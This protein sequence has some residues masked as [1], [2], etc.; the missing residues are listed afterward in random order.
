[1]SRPAITVP[2]TA[3][4]IPTAVP[5]SA[6]STLPRV[7]VAE[8]NPVC[9]LVLVEQLRVIGGCQVVACEDG[10]A[11]WATLQQGA[12]LL[13]T[14]IGLPGMGGL[15]LA[16]AIRRAEGQASEADQSGHRLPII[17]VTATADSKTRRE[18][19]AAG[20]DMVLAKPVSTEM[21][22]HLVGRYL[23]RRPD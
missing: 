4:P 21:L 23:S 9:L 13:L 11:A 1:M 20:I 10:H 14:D 12:A 5:A 18:C 17:A 22:T 3:A 15:G 2:N 8:D 7:V 19:L 6:L 16:R